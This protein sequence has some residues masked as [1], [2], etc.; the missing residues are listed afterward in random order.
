MNEDQ[1]GLHL[2]GRM[3]ILCVACIALFLLLNYV[4]FQLYVEH[5]LALQTTYI[6]A[7]DIPPRTKIKEEDLLEVRIPYGY[8]MDHACT[9]KEEIVGMYTEIQGMIPAGSPFYRSMLYREKDL[10][11][12]AVMQL[13]SGQTSY[14]MNTDVSKLGSIV[15]GMRADIH[16]TVE[17]RGEKPLTGCLFRNVRVLSVKDHK[18]LEL[19][20]EGSTGIPYLIEVA[21]SSGDIPLLTLAESTGEIRMFPT[22]DSY[23]TDTEA[24]LIQDS[25]LSMY[26]QS[27]L[28]AGTAEE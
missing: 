27:L 6:A 7:C 14:A 21:V 4:L 28:S 9:K 23:R 26:L 18:G 12:R 15:S 16:V 11:D 5:S 1:K 8:V 20:D 10:P 19:G 17:R 25:E 3:T 13:R 2:T 24:E 22:S